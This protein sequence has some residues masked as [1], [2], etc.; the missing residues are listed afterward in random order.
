MG[1]AGELRVR[2]ELILRG[3]SPA[4][5][6]NDDGVDIILADNGKRLQV[7]TSRRPNHSP[8]NYSYKYSF[9]IRHMQFRE[10]KN[11]VYNRT[12]TRRSY[13]D[14][15]DFFVFWCVE[16]DIF[17]VIPVDVIGEKVSFTVPTPTNARKYRIND[18]KSISKYEQYRGAWDLLG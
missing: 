13:K 9:S 2:S 5:C 17:Y 16:H 6:D 4:V 7:K 14:K 11:G 3:F 15:A 8:S 18:R 12:Y 10:G 1:K